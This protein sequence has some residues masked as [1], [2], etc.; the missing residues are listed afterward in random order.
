M[1][2]IF[3]QKILVFH[4]VWV[5]SF[6]HLRHDPLTPTLASILLPVLFLA[7]FVSNPVTNYLC[8]HLT[9]L[10]GAWTNFVSE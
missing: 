1:K 4:K 5:L 9:T 7:T 6:L 8:E 3:C 10:V 2:K